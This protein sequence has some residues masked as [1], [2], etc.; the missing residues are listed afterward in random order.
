MDMRHMHGGGTG[1]MGPYC[2]REVKEPQGWNNVKT[3]PMKK[4]IF[5]IVHLLSVD[6]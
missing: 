6:G 3:L 1:R 2:A 5:Y 4:V